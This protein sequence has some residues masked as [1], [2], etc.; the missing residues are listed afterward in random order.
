M[1]KSRLTRGGA[2]PVG[3]PT[4]TV[5]VVIDGVNEVIEVR[6]MNRGEMLHLGK[7]SD[8][9]GQAVAEQYMLS[10]CM[11]DPK[12]TMED[13]ADWQTSGPGMEMHPVVL[14]VNALS[15]A[16]KDAEKSG[17]PGV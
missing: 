7:L 5:D 14:K 3:L 12:M 1:D 15:G 8:N 17:V 11:L 2:G 9:E 16:G 4:G 10:S 13:V 6:G